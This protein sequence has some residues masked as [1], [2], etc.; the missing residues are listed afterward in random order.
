MIRFRFKVRKDRNSIDGYPIILYANINGKRFNFYTNI[1][2]DSVS[3]LN[4]NKVSKKDKLH[5]EKNKK[6]E[7]ILTTLRLLVLKG[8]VEDFRETMLSA[9]ERPSKQSSTLLIYSIEE[10]IKTKNNLGTIKV[11]KDTINKIK[12]YNPN[13]TIEE[14]NAQWL[15]SFESYCSQTMS[16]NG[17]SKHFRNIKAV[18]NYLYKEGKTDNQPFKTFKIKREETVHRT[19][20]IELLR[21]VKTVECPSF[22]REYRDVFMLMIYLVGINPKDLAYLKED[23]IQDGRIVYHRFKTGKLY[24]IK[25]EPEAQE[26]IDKYRGVSHLLRSLDRCKDYKT[27]FQH[28]NAALKKLGMEYKDGVGYTGGKAICKDL[29]AY[30]ARH[31]W[32]SIAFEIGIPKDTISLALGHSNGVKVTD[33][34]IK[35]DLSKVDEANRKVIDYINEKRHPR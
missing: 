32:A 22:M 15:A 2:L 14:I 16:I 6:L 20:A 3:H 11:Y 8:D 33:T 19:I 21:R 24:S 17:Y 35:Y 29:S 31:I 5:R 13:T 12:A 10:F 7:Y 34:Y 1:F 28:M 27:Y 4:N 23:N 25:I 26:I 9:L 30:W 18:F